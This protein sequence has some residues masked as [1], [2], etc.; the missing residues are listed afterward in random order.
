M[1]VIL[2]KLSFGNQL[3]KLGLVIG[4][5]AIILFEVVHVDGST[6]TSSVDV[7]GKW[8]SEFSNLFNSYQ[9]ENAD[10]ISSHN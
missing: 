3:V 7:L 2:I 8:K 1:N 10:G 6:T 9:C 4:I 5:T